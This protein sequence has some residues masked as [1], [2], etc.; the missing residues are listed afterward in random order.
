[1]ATVSGTEY[2]MHIAVWCEWKERSSKERIDIMIG[3][4]DTVRT[5]ELADIHE[6]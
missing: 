2:E 3:F 5:L 1:M 4:G 6:P